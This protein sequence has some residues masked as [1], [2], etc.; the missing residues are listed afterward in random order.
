MDDRGHNNFINNG[1]E[2]EG[3]VNYTESTV[4]KQGWVQSVQL[5]VLTMLG[6]SYPMQWHSKKVTVTKIIRAP[7][8][9]MLTLYDLQ[10]ANYASQ[11]YTIFSPSE[12]QPPGIY[13][14]VSGKI[15]AD[16]LYYP[17]NS[18]ARG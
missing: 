1:K 17:F 5:Q 14:C 16:I 15:L 12:A 2:E 3:T 6:K 11:W 7:F 4:Q 13:S 9:I 18:L 8:I 10:Y